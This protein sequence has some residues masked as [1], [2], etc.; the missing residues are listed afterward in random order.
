MCYK[1]CYIGKHRIVLL[2]FMA[3]LN[4]LKK[5]FQS[6]TYIGTSTLKTPLSVKHIVFKDYT[7]INI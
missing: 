7:I 6:S 5:D 1:L 3:N 4:N 2:R